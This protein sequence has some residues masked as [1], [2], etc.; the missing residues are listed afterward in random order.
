MLWYA[1]QG[2]AGKCSAAFPAGVRA[3]RGQDAP[4][5]AGKMPALQSV[6]RTIHLLVPALVPRSRKWNRLR[7]G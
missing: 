2:G 6:A 1:Q 5:T 7:A 4:G 3:R